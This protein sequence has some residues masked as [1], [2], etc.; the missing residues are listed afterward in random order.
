MKQRG[1]SIAFVVV[2]GMGA[3]AT[4]ATQVKVKT[5]SVD[6]AWNAVA[7]HDYSLGA[8]RV[9][10]P[11]MKSALPYPVVSAPDIRLAYVK[12]WKDADGNYHYGN[13]V[14]IQMDPP[15]WVLPDGTID[16]INGAGAPPPPAHRRD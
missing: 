11:A 4:P 9:V 13:W 5:M 2:L 12:R 8:G 1:G 10:K 15:R 6:E 3:C 16:P 14:A 7:T